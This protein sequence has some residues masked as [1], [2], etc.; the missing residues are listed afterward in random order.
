MDNLIKKLR[1]IDHNWHEAACS[2]AINEI[3]QLREALGQMIYE[4]THLSPVEND[5]SHWCKI[6]KETLAI[7]REAL[8]Q[9]SI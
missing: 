5:G 4:T 2:E 6:S 7:A 9:E 3:K 8:K 1:D